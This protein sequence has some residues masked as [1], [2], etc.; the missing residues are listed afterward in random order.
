MMTTLAA[1]QA[2][3]VGLSIAAIHDRL[4]HRLNRTRICV[5]SQIGCLGVQ[6]SGFGLI[7]RT[8]L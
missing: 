2:L 7:L 3:G 6:N 4:A 1:R 8:P 5:Q